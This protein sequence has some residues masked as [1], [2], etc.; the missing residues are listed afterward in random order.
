M[1]TLAY[2]YSYLGSMSQ[3]SLA[4]FRD[5]VSSQVLDF[6]RGSQ[7]A[8]AAGGV[9]G[10]LLDELPEPV[11]TDGQYAGLHA[12]IEGAQ[13]VNAGVGVFS[14]YI[15]SYTGSQIDLKYGTG[16]YT[17]ATMNLASN[18]IGAD[19]AAHLQVNG[20]QLPTLET[21]GLI[22]GAAAVSRLFSDPIYYPNR[23]YTGWSGVMLFPYLGYDSFY[24]DWLLTTEAVQATIDRLDGTQETVT[25]KQYE[26]TYDLMAAV[27]SHIRTAERLTPADM[28]Q[29][30]LAYSD[31]IDT[32]HD[33]LIA[34]TASF[35]ADTY[36][37]PAT[38]SF[39]IGDVLPYASPASWLTSTTGVIVGTMKSDGPDLFY[40]DP[41]RTKFDNFIIHGG[42]GDDIIHADPNQLLSRQTLNLLVDG[43][44]GMDTL[45][46]ASVDASLHIQLESVAVG[47]LYERSGKYL[48]G[49]HD[50]GGSDYARDYA[51]SIEG[52]VG[53]SRSD[54]L[55]IHDLD[56]LPTSEATPHYF[57]DLHG[58]GDMGNTLDLS[59]W[60]I[61]F[62]RSMWGADV[63]ATHGGTA[64]DQAALGYTGQDVWI[65]LSAT[66]S[67]L[68]DSVQNIITG[69]GN[70]I[71]HGNE[72]GNLL[73][74][75]G[76]VN[77]VFGNGGADIFVVG[78]SE[79]TIK[80]A[81]ADDR[82]YI[83]FSAI[84]PA[85]TRPDMALEIKGGL[86]LLAAPSAVGAEVD[87]Q[88]SASFYPSF[89]DGQAYPVGGPFMPG[90]LVLDSA[91][92]NQI[93]VNFSLSGS[94][95]RIK[96]HAEDANEQFGTASFDI[97][98]EGYEPG[99][100]GL[101]FHETFIPDVTRVNHQAA[102]LH[103][104]SHADPMDGILQDYHDASRALL[105]F[106]ELPH[107]DGVWYG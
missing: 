92:E 60:S 73:A 62:D 9:Y 29:L 7:L 19:F 91:L 50:A 67:L 98:V 1:K 33:D 89:L 5:D 79:T 54:I 10:S 57:I 70:D 86:V 75:G 8:G 82:L 52:L 100:L 106:Q 69:S 43:G 80:D 58:A 26:G 28:A 63:A 15:R 4:R 13:D 87:I 12:W 66:H 88:Y 42:L 101:R 36:G 6:V 40:R 95:L 49:K 48:I 55:S 105:A 46:Y 16:I 107:F 14:K 85:T 84:N 24:K 32:L 25:I 39:A 59:S 102:A 11:L 41:D 61:S 83:P 34:L 27:A 3:E 21:L 51:F 93:F 45:S 81:D 90:K 99:D 104:T 65:P 103:Y 35:L 68:I 56:L 96:F 2:D 97:I 23:D 44:E 78:R 72:E 77:V 31:I 64:D 37:L 18:T 17:N 22:D 94:D 74:P 38:H 71:L 20:G 76:G 30:G 47:D 53:S